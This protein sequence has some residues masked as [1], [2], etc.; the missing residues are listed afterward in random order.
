[1]YYASCTSA[2]NGWSFLHPLSRWG[3][4]AEYA[5]TVFFDRWPSATHTPDAI[6][7]IVDQRGVQF[8]SPEPNGLLV[9]PGDLRQQT[10]TTVAQPLG[11]QS[12]KPAPLV[13]IQATEQ[14]Q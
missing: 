6:R 11:L 4:Y 9:H 14:E 7:W 3:L 12:A 8:F 2:V 10:V 5:T 1:M 13:L